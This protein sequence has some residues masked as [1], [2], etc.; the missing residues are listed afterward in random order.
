MG[1][2]WAI[3]SGKGGVGKS[4]I[5]LSLAVG[6]SRAKQ[7]VVLVDADAGLRNLDLL[8][9]VENKIVFDIMDVIEETASLKQATLKI[10]S[11][12]GLS[13]LS[14][15][16]TQDQDKFPDG[17]LELILATL[18]EQYDYVIVDCPAG[19]GKAVHTMTSVCDEAIIVTTPDDVS[20]RDADHLS[21]MLTRYANI[22]PYVVVNRLRPSFV[23]SG[24]MYSAQTVAQTLD[25]TL[26]SVIPEDDNVLRC[27]IKR[28]PA[29]DA[30]GS[31]SK[32]YEKI[33]NT[34]LTGVVTKHAAPMIKKSFFSRFLRP[35]GVD[36]PQ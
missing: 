35:K 2:I 9:G 8:L 6:L 29:I 14:A 32:A 5:S 33:V 27:Q 26:I 10:K 4:T 1:Q 22:H 15:S 34:C 30:G 31:L 23:E 18:K 12:P 36:N 24:L 28:I 16:Q 20:V 21:G 25:A 13:L 19:I 11:Y 7:N 17:A 3:V